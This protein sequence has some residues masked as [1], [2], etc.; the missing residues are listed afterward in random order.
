MNSASVDESV[1][2]FCFLDVQEIRLFP[3]Y[4]RKPVIDFIS[5]G[6]FAQSEST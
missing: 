5:S 4:T 2:N 1:T 3:K 6:S